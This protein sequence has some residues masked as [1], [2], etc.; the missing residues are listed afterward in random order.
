MLDGVKELRFLDAL[1]VVRAGVV[2]CPGEPGQL[3]QDSVQ[4]ALVDAG[5]ATVLAEL[6]RVSFEFLQDLGANVAAQKNSLDVEQACDDGPARKVGIVLQ[7]EACLLEQKLQAQKRAQPF[8]LNGC[9]NSARRA[10][11]VA[12]SGTFRHLDHAPILRQCGRSEQM[13]AISR[14]QRA[15]PSAASVR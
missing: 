8:G 11:P 14:I 1:Q 3:L 9:S 2:Q 6:L 5:L 15:R 7:V 10:V 4:A 13:S 12:A